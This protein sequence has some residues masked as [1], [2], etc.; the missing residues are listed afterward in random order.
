[1]SK[2]VR[3]SKAYE[4]L[5]AVAG[6]AAGLPAGKRTPAGV[7]EDPAAAEIRNGLWEEYEIRLRD[8]QTYTIDDLLAWLRDQGVKVGRTSVHRDRAA[9]MASERSLV[10]AA[11]KAKSI[12]AAV[13]HMDEGDLARGQRMLS[14]QL[15]FN[16]M[17]DLPPDV[18]EGIS[19]PQLIKLMNCGAKITKVHAETEILNMRI[20]E[21]SRQAKEETDKLTA[22]SA[23]KKLS[24]SE[25]YKMIDKV[26]KGES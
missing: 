8:T 18:M 13:G 16:A 5:A 12:C 1:M 19:I 21:I 6:K 26:M 15:I 23:D 2:N 24:R 17:S 20:E 4:G 10:L 7:A 14:M 3:H 22:K 9:I 11:A 25:V